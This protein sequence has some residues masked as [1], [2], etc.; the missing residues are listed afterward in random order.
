MNLGDHL[1]LEES[2]KFCTKFELSIL[3]DFSVLL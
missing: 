2:E 3:D 1:K